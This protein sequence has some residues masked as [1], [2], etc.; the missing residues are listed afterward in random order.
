M[1]CTVTLS[2]I[3]SDGIDLEKAQALYLTS[4]PESERRDAKKWKDMVLASTS[5]LFALYKISMDDAF[6]G[7]LSCW[8]FES[9]LYIEHFAI[10]SQQRG[11]GLGSATLSAFR[12]LF[13]QKPIVLEAEVPIEEMAIRRIQFYQRNGFHVCESP[14]MQP[15]Y[16]QD[17]KWLELKLLSTSPDFASKQFETIKRTIYHHVYNIQE[18]QL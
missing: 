11:H 16:H 8:D 9:F 17:G 6:A 13:P 2:K 4:F 15:P 12:T 18:E 10:N 3:Q 14:Y 5:T 7:I 1:N